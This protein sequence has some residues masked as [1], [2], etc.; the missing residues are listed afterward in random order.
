MS[1]L[2]LFYRDRLSDS[3]LTAFH[4]VPLRQQ[5]QLLH[6]LWN[7]FNRRG[8]VLSDCMRALNA[9]S[10]EVPDIDLVNALPY[11][12]LANY[13][14]ALPRAEDGA[15][16][17]FVVVKVESDTSGGNLK[18]LLSSKFHHL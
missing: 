17:Q 2:E 10:R 14:L 11:T 7:P 16:R 15:Y 12:I 8:K 4:H 18:L 1:D 5:R 3:Q 9:A 6:V 13:I